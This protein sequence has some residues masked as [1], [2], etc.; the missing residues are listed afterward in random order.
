MNF[1]PTIIPNAED[2]LNAT[3]IF[4]GIKKTI[5][6]KDFKGGKISNW[7]GSTELDFTHAD[8]NGI[9]VLDISQ[10]F[11]ATTITVPADWRIESDLS[12]L[13]AVVDDNRDNVYQTGKSDK[14][15]LIKGLSAC[16][17]VEIQNY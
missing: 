8:L 9:A 13:F 10:A 15:L 1:Q 11:G 16:A 12:Q 2:H 4:G 6:S 17:S 7:F 14:V 5:L 3:A